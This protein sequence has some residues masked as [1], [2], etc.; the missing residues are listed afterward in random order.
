MRKPW[1]GPALL[2]AVCA[3][4]RRPWAV[5]LLGV[6]LC[7]PAV[8]GLRVLDDHVLELAATGRGDVIPRAAGLDLFQFASGDAQENLALMSRGAL[9]PWWSDPELK[10]R[11]FR[12]LSSLTHR[13]DFALWADCSQLMYIQSLLWL[14]VVLALV[15]RLYTNVEGARPRVAAL[16]ALA[17]ALSDV[18]GAV[19]G[20]LSNRNALLAAAGALACL[21]AYQRARREGHRASRWL[22]PLWLGLG[23]FSGEV[24]LGAWAF[25]VADAIMLDERPVRRRLAALLPNLLVTLAWAGAHVASGAGSEGSG[26][27][28]HPLQDGAAFLRALPERA[29]ILFGAALGPLPAELSLLGSRSVVP[30]AL[31][32]ALML[33]SALLIEQRRRASDPELRFWWL[34]AALSLLPVAASFP[35]DRLL[36]LVNVAALPIVSR[37]LVALWDESATRTLAGAVLAAC[38]LFTHLVLAPLS[39]IWRA[40]QM[41]VLGAKQARAFDCLERVPQLQDKTLL[42]LGAPADLFVSYLQVE[43]AARGLPHPEHV[44]WFS[45]PGAVLD[46]RVL[47][48]QSLSLARAGGFFVTPLEA[49]YRRSGAALMPGRRVSLPELSAEVRELDAAGAV[50]RVELGF[51]QPLGSERYVFLVWRGGRYVRAPAEALQQLQIPPAPSLIE[52]LSPVSPSER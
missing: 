17:Y 4:S 40:R 37:S 27:Y 1:L 20:W 50:A 19:V 9:L 3:L 8:G 36:V 5:P 35:S 49:L 6:A 43:R 11:F 45:N 48:D 14:A 15:A 22:A 38:L 39:S 10:I 13:L 18:H 16:A 7:L 42:V 52:L 24:G 23:L 33:L 28:L 26:L 34:S 47:G 41:Q 46:V 29:T 30:L 25:L 21:L 32:V 44:V 12:P 2:A 51:A 31:G